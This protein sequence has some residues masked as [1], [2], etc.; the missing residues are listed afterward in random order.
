MRTRE[1]FA[2]GDNVEVLDGPFRDHRVK[3]VEISGAM[4]KILMPL[5]GTMRELDMPLET[6]SRV[7]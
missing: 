6:L 5:F 3:V 4:A 7:A 2:A 1:E